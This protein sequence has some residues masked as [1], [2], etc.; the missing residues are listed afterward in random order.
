MRSRRRLGGGWPGSRRWWS[1]PTCED[2]FDKVYD[3]GLEEVG[4]VEADRGLHPAVENQW[5]EKLEKGEKTKM[6]AGNG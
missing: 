4:S 2:V 1:P 5:R 6:R 3:V